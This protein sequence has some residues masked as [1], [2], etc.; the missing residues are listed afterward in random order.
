M[1]KLLSSDKALHFLYSFFI[2]AILNRFLPFWVGIVVAA[3]VGVA[4]E[5]YDKRKGGKIDFLDLLADLAGI[6]VGVI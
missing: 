5:V 2:V 4:K 3:A 6:A 1:L